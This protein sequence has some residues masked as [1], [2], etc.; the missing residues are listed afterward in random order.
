MATDQL[1]TARRLAI[2]PVA[3]ATYF[4]AILPQVRRELDGWRARADAI[5]DQALRRQ[6]VA[7]LTDK[8]SNV[9]A[10]AV[11][12]ILA[13]RAR[14]RAAIRAIV[15]LQV[16]I[17]YIDLLGERDVPD[18]L[19]DGL[20][21]HRTLAA[22]VTPGA[23]AEDWYRLHPRREDGGY[24]S[25]LVRACQRSVGSLPAAGALRP[26]MIAAAQRCGEGQSHTH[27]AAHGDPSTLERWALGLG[28]PP[29]YSWWEVAAGAS[30][31]VAVHALI[32]AAADRRSTTEGARLIDAAYFPSIGALTVLLDDLVDRDRDAA[33]GDH[34]YIDY[35]SS[36][37]QAGER[38]A[39]IAVRAETAI[40][41]VPHGGRHAAILAGVLAFYLSAPTARAPFAGPAR[42]LL[43]AA[44]GPTVR[45][46]AAMMGL[47][48]ARKRPRSVGSTSG[49]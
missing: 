7:A 35:Y 41:P 38:L 20:R 12:A 33:S 47:R 27:A 26:Q 11:F 24:L 23:A 32:A 17:D 40:D 36:G 13:P 10:V 29:G 31:S 21:L 44:A 2:L 30:S 37:E 25:G 49:P 34:N 15:A 28:A 1:R 19:Q 42:E 3:L 8:A 39:A 18:P 4:A 45:P 22:A 16:A 43:L 48:R 6:A 5:P 9:E 14:R 46:L